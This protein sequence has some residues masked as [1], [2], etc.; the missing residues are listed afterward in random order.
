MDTS[1]EKQDAC[2]A[3]ATASE[4]T[5]AVDNVEMEMEI[6]EI[7]EF[8][9]DGAKDGLLPLAEEVD[10][11]Q[12]TEGA[13]RKVSQGYWEK[14]CDR[15]QQSKIEPRCIID[16][17]YTDAGYLNLTGN[18]RLLERAYCFVDTCDPE[19]EWRQLV[20]HVHSLSKWAEATSIPPQ[21]RVKRQ[22]MSVNV[23]R[24]RQSMSRMPI[25]RRSTGR[26]NKNM[27]RRAMVWFLLA[28]IFVEI[29][30]SSSKMRIFLKCN[31]ALI[32]LISPKARI[33]RMTA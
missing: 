26:A 30:D 9:A 8:L 25:R 31:G 32:P 5:T 14:F 10:V 3:S 15:V 33:G 1:E 16:F 13:T 21:E 19:R 24:S 11:V 23:G 7:L 27:V 28:A 29:G 4:S 12:D 2:A 6:D 22:I 18:A 17:A 20:V